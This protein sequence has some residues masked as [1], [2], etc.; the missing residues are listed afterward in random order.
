MARSTDEVTY[1]G[2]EWVPQLAAGDTI[3]WPPGEVIADYY[4]RQNQ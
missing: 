1:G 3:N 2:M 4:N